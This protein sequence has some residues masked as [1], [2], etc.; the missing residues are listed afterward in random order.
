MITDGAV[1]SQSMFE[2][3]ISNR[4]QHDVETDDDE[5]ADGDVDD[6]RGFETIKDLTTIQ[7]TKEK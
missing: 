7:H 3:E 2:G 6:Y 1:D 5:G 4:D